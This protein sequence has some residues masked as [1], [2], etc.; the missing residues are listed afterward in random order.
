MGLHRK[1]ALAAAGSIV[2]TLVV[3]WDLSRFAALCALQSRLAAAGPELPPESGTEA[4][5]VLTGDHGRI[6]RALD[7]LRRRNT[8]LLV[9]SGAAKGISLRDLVNQQGDAAVNI[10]ETWPRIHL[11]SESETTLENARE[12]A[13][14]VR[15]KKINRLILITSDYHMHRAAILF[16]RFLPHVTLVEHP[17]PSEIAHGFLSSKG[18][19]ASWKICVEYVKLSMLR[20][21]LSLSPAVEK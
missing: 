12:T 19:A 18:L 6:P 9:I 17:T 2:I 8:P 4:I 10:H 3:A 16:R 11:E 15:E 7:L 13:R 21:L 5:V 1:W 20:V 14:I